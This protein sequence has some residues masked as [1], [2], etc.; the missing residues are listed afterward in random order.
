MIVLHLVMQNQNSVF[1]EL[2]KEN[3]IKLNPT[4]DKPYCRVLCLDLQ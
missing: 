3:C 2:Y 4:N 1:V